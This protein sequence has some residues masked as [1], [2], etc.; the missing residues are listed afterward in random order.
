MRLQRVY[1]FPVFLFSAHDILLFR[2]PFGSR[3]H[4]TV[5]HKNLIWLWYLQIHAMPKA[6][7][8][9]NNNFHFF[10]NVSVRAFKITE[11]K[12]FTC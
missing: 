6:T 10:D 11:Y 1:V 9:L 4:V 5:I 3:I 7:F 12:E 8:K 2:L